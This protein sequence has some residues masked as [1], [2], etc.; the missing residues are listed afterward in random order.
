MTR[1]RLLLLA[2]SLLSIL[3]LAAACGDDDAM[4]RA[5]PDGG[6]EASVPTDGGDTD[7]GS[8]ACGV[9]IPTTYD[10]PAF[11]TNAKVELE[12]RQHFAALEAKMREPEG[13]SMAVVTTADLT[14]IYAQGAPSL[15]AVS[16]ANAQSL[17][18]AY[19]TQY[20][21]AVGKAWT[22]SDADNDAGA[23]ATG[24]KYMD[25]YHF[26]PTGID[27]RET[28]QKVLLTGAFYNDA[29]GVAAAPMTDASVD[30]LLA[31]FGASTSLANRTDADA[32]EIGDE[33][34]AE[35]ASKRDDDTAPTGP[36]R[37]IRS[38]LLTLKVAVPAGEKCKKEVDDAIATYFAEW[39]KASLATVIF[40]LN[41]AVTN[42]GATKNTAALHG[43][44]EALGFVQGWKGLPADKRK[45]TDA[46]VDG[47]LEKIGAAS[48]YKLVL[49]S[50]QTA[51][52]L[53][54]NSAINDIAA[55]YGFSAAE[56]EAFK[57]S[58]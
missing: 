17:V 46:Q 21:D 22:P 4:V 36:Y 40:Y 50:Y 56:V 5:R 48:P 3:G 8:L 47:L 43:F 45:I 34:I 26:G 32:G 39:E 9:S 11:T 55:I 14:A 49:V 54:I 16:T 10:A 25:T 24:G 52:V 51:R 33:L 57:K 44:G 12:L 28:T 7:A 2:S 18:D 31:A 53:A 6:A 29:L 42:A 1:S 23:A 41:A 27:L 38:A 37:K 58:F 35:Y 20:G 13:T 15:R 19:L 30:R